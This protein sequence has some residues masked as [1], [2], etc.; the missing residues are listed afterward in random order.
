M[1]KNLI[2]LKQEVQHSHMMQKDKI[3]SILSSES[4]HFLKNHPTHIGWKL[5][6]ISKG[7][8][9]NDLPYLQLD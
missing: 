8:I 2:L 7:R 3:I 1:L 9:S 5:F 6:K 4:K